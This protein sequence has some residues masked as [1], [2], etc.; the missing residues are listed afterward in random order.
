MRIVIAGS[1]GLIGTALVKRLVT[2]GHQVVR[3]VRGQSTPSDGIRWDPSAGVLPQDALDG[4]DAVVNLAGAGIGDHRWTDS[5]KRELV[6][7]RLQTTAL[8]AQTMAARTT[9]PTVFLSGSAIG[10]YGDRGDEVLDETSSP[11]TG[12]LADLCAQWEAATAP[13]AQ[14][15]VRVA[16]LRTGVVLSAQ[17][18]ALKKQLPLFKLGVGGKFG[19]GRH[20]QSWISIDD[21]VAAVEHLLT[22]DVDGPVNL[23]APEPVTNATF[24]KTLGSVLHR[25]AVVPIPAFGPRLVLGRELADALLFSGQ[26][27]VPKRLSASGF[28]FA[29]PQLDAALRAQLGR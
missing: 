27:V 19:S 26:R 28:Q 24:A 8:L 20:W 3:L 5:Y 25:P 9:R 17:G 18:G 29:H 22:A 11:G 16:H 23:T 4:T 7:S 13:A 10:W 1:S 21:H 14:A 15:G 6:E 2:N 12:F